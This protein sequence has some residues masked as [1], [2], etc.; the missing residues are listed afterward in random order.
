MNPTIDSRTAEKS[1]RKFGGG[2]M[3]RHAAGAGGVGD[4]GG[5]E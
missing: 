4:P 3:G 2:M 1:E 5:P